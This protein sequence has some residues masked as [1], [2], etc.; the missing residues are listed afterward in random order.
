D[1]ALDFIVERKR[2]DDLAASIMDGRFA[3]QKSRLKKTNIRHIFYLH[4]KAFGPA[5]RFKSSFKNSLMPEIINQALTNTIVCDGFFLKQTKDIDAT[6]SFLKSMTERLIETYSKK[7]IY[8]FEY[9]EFIS[10]N[11]IFGK[12]PSI[13]SPFVCLVDHRSMD[14]CL[15]KN[16][17][18][19]IKELFAKSLTKIGG[20]GWIKA[21]EIIKI[22]PTPRS[23]I[24]AYRSCNSEQEKSDLLSNITYGGFKRK[25]GSQTSN[26]IY[27]FFMH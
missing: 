9:N 21:I 10:L 27:K 2:C 24:N 26:A 19:S 14:L 23:L 4:E 13:D 25:I 20:V 8:C 11:N 12:L 7:T 15:N 17:N 18:P 22:Y 1:I 3:E 5:N 16:Y 6:V